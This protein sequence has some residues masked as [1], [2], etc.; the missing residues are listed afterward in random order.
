MDLKSGFRDYLSVAIV[1]RP[2]DTLSLFTRNLYLFKNLNNGI[3]HFITF[4]A[5]VIA[6]KNS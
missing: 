4:D 3:D 6:Y 2:F 1:S 5:I